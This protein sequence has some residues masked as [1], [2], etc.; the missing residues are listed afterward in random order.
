MKFGTSGLRGLSVDLVGRASALYATAFMQHL[1]NCD[2]VRPG[3]MVA[4]GR[5][6]RASSPD[7]AAS[8]TGALAE[9]GYIVADCGCVP[10]PALA[11]FAR[12]NDI[13][14]LM[15]TGSHIPADRNGIKFYSPAGE[16][17][18]ADELEIERVADE[19]D[20]GGFQA[21]KGMPSASAVQDYS[22]TCASLFFS[23]NNGFL[24]EKALAGKR[25]GLYEH[26]T[27]ASALLQRLL[28]HYGAE[29]VPLGRSEQ[30]VALDTEAIPPETV[31]ELKKW[32]LEYKL[33]A[34]VSADGDG[35]RPLVADET[36]APLR[37]D[38]LGIVAADLLLP[39]VVV[40]PVTSNS[41]V[42]SAGAY[43]V[44]RTKVGS[45]YVIQGMLEAI[46]AGIERVLGFEANGGL[47]L[48]GQF[49]VNGT[50]LQELPTRDCM[51]PILSILFLASKRDCKLSTMQ[52]H[53]GMKHT[54]AGRIEDF[55]FAWSEKLMRF[56]KKAENLP[57]FLA[58]IGDVDSTD[59]TDG[60]R[61]KLSNGRI[62]H[63]RASGNAPEMR[64]YVE[65]ESEEAA[66][67]LLSSSLHIVR[68]WERQ[69]GD[70]NQS[71]AKGYSL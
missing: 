2:L 3:A 21:P 19:I 46:N 45:P 24:P 18:K 52:K 14:A 68:R 69:E 50:I 10:T 55:P 11:H 23:R 7:I 22:A 32:A 4:L 34:I 60:V 8:I 61:A 67:T 54:A 31:L 33:D 26:S 39:D 37:G 57:G 53:Y 38:L 40:T 35:D 70:H 9:L 66:T 48:A 64:C 28:I 13:A 30:F 49:E 47:L 59:S 25:I 5:D 58:D 36:G 29:V 56:L 1:E 65:A 63:F 15:V 6:F 41:G 12:Q 51:V 43:Q 42:D 20:A 16:I 27:V 71:S 17:M 62:V 44:L